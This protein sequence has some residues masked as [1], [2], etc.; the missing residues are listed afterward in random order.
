MKKEKYKVEIRRNK[1]EKGEKEARLIASRIER[2]CEG[3]NPLRRKKKWKSSYEGV[4][5]WRSSEVQKVNYLEKIHAKYK[6]N[7][8]ITLVVNLREVYILR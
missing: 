5:K 4:I 3:K 8:I 7:P 6:R 1:K 2:A